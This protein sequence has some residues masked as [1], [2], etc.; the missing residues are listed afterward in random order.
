M[1]GWIDRLLRPAEATPPWLVLVASQ[2]VCGVLFGASMGSFGSW[3]RDRM[4]YMLYAGLKVPLLLMTALLLSLPCFYILNTL[5]GLRHDFPLALRYIMTAQASLTIILAALAP[6]TLFWYASFSD[7]QQ[8]ILFN[9]VLFAVA[10]AAAQVR[11]RRLYRPLVAAN[12][13]HRTLLRMWLVLYVFVATQLAWVL[14]PFVGAP[15]TP[16]EFFRTESWGNAYVA[17]WRMVR[18][19]VF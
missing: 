17:I 5:A 8:A 13:R 2:I 7:Y 15:N 3:D 10:S 14:R 4:F 6:Y 16:A 1:L 11:L 19:V 18:S 12:A 9:G